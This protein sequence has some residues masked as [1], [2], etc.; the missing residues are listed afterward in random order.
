MRLVVWVV[1][2]ENDYGKGTVLSLPVHHGVLACDYGR[3]P[4]NA[5]AYGDCMTTFFKA[6]SEWIVA[7]HQ[8]EDEGRAYSWLRY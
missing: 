5:C 4:C 7:Q 2:K 1:H 8:C 6:C 3:D